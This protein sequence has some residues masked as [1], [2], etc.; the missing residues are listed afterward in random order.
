M[1]P[2]HFALNEFTALTASEVFDIWIYTIPAIVVIVRSYS[3]I[4]SWEIVTIPFLAI[5]HCEV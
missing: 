5:R 3:E 1:L 2:I 4:L